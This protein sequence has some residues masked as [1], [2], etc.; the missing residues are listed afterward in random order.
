VSTA[1]GSMISMYSCDALHMLRHCIE[2][3]YITRI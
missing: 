2:E 1:L 3:V